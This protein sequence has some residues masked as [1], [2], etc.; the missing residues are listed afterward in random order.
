MRNTPPN[1]EAGKPLAESVEP[2]IPADRGLLT[3]QETARVLRISP[4]TL[5]YWTAGRR[6]LLGYVKL[7]KA[8]RFV[9]G[10][11]LRFIEERKIRSP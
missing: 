1:G 9:V 8:K 7:G 6:P 3:S 2:A 5:S 10:D 11:V 4:R